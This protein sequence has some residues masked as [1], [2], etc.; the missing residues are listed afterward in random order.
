MIKYDVIRDGATQGLFAKHGECPEQS[1][2]FLRGLRKMGG[3]EGLPIA[4]GNVFHALLEYAHHPK[5]A[6]L[7]VKAMVKR[8]LDQVSKIHREWLAENPRASTAERERQE[9]ACA[10]ASAVFPGYVERYHAE[11]KKRKWVATEQEFCIEIPLED[12][13]TFRMRGKM[14]G[15]YADVGSSRLKLLET[16]TKGQIDMDFIEDW[17]A[18]DLQTGVYLLACKNI[19]GK[20]PRSVLYNVIRRPQLRQKKGETLV[21]FGERCAKDVIDRPD[22]YFFRHEHIITKAELGRFEV[23]IEERAQA[24]VDWWEGKS[25]HYRNSS[26]C[27]GRYGRC[28]MFDYCAG[29]KEHYVLRQKLF[30]E[31]DYNQGV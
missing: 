4:F 26:A 14:D 6:R 23:Q 15:V 7:S 12:G 22:F 31:L 16:K 17:L 27:D 24:F 10:F 3:S 13:R 18:W 30:P 8:G 29:R 2:L 28:E 21:Q 1:R 20:Y 25:P 19:V 5:Q 11:D 9:M